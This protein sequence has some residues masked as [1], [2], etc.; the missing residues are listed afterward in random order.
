LGVL[1]IQNSK[2]PDDITAGKAY[3]KKASQKGNTAAAKFLDEYL[4]S[5][6]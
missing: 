3:L 4:K 5:N 2:G 1:S 6:P